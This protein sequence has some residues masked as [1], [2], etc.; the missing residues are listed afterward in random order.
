VGRGAP[1]RE[2]RHDIAQCGRQ[3]AEFDVEDLVLAHPALPMFAAADCF[4]RHDS[5]RVRAA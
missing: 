3:Q 2:R 5:P 1:T 4:I